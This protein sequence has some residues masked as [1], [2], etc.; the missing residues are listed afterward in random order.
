MVRLYLLILLLQLQYMY[1]IIMLLISFAD[2]ILLCTVHTHKLKSLI[3]LLLKIFTLQGKLGL[4][5]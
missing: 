1:L 3:P 2:C 4:A 5:R